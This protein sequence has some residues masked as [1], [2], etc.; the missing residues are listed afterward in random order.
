MFDV[1]IKIWNFQL[2]VAGDAHFTQKCFECGAKALQLQN[3]GKR[4]RVASRCRAAMIFFL[5]TLTSVLNT[6][7]H[8]LSIVG[9]GL[10]IVALLLAYAFLSFCDPLIFLNVA[11]RRLLWEGEKA[12]ASVICVI[13]GAFM[14]LSA[15]LDFNRER[16][17][18]RVVVIDYGQILREVPT[19]ALTSNPLIKY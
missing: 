3:L 10:S 1:G 16:V 8:G 9:H 17:M 2:N 7:W 18:S 15:L 11:G 5:G 4:R 19:A 6:L 13:L 14:T 12:F